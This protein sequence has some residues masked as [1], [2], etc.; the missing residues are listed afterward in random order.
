[1]RSVKIEEV[2]YNYDILGVQ[3][4]TS[5]RKRMSILV[6]DNNLIKLYVKGADSEIK[7]RLHKDNIPSQVEFTDKYIELLSQKGYRTLYVGYKI[8]DDETYQKF[9]Q[10]VHEAN[11]LLDFKKDRLDVAYHEL[12]QGFMLLGATVVEDKLQDMVPETIRD[13]RMAKIKIWMLTGDKFNTAYNIGLSCNLISSQM[14]V[15]QIRGEEGDSLEKFLND[16]LYFINNNSNS[17]SI[18]I[19]SVALAKIL[20][21]NLILPSFLEAAKNAESVICCRTSPLQKAEIVKA[22]KDFIPT[23]TT[24]AIGD[25][26]N[27]VSMILEAH[28]GNSQIYFHNSLKK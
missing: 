3:E 5:E 19:D 9:K 26:G 2:V 8:I 7:S 14:K 17:Y 18:I 22:M 25:G 1:M 20:S 23:A 12:E 13:L 21:N 27:D 11:Q 16:Y 10:E 4:F 28:V 24:L 6:K 15:F